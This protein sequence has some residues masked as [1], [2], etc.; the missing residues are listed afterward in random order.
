MEQSNVEL[1]SSL[2]PENKRI[3]IM[4]APYSAVTLEGVKEIRAEFAKQGID[5]IVVLYGN[6]AVRPPDFEHTWV[7]RK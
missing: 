4:R 5:L 1:I 6:N 7:V 3:T 2:S